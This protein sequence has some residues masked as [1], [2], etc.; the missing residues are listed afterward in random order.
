MG[1]PVTGT[2]TAGG[3]GRN[4]DSEPI[5]GFMRAVNYSSGKCNT[6]SCEFITLVA[7]K[8]PSFLMARN[9]EKVYD[10]K[11]QRY[12]K[13]DNRTAILIPPCN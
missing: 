1:T 4:S 9:N 10:K 6:F 7:G 13:V 2:S 5:S 12:A 11:S 3:V 8:R